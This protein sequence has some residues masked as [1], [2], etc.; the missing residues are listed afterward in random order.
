MKKSFRKAI[1]LAVFTA[2]ILTISVTTF[3]SG[4]NSV[5]AE[6]RN[7]YNSALKNPVAMNNRNAVVYPAVISTVFPD[8]KLADTV[9]AALGKQVSDS[10]TKADLETITTLTYVGTPQTAMYNLT[11]LDELT[12]L[13]QVEFTS[14]FISDLSLVDWSKLPNLTSLNLTNNAIKDLTTIDLTQ[15]S[16]LQ[17]LILDHNSITD[18]SGVNWAALTAITNISIAN[19]FTGWLEGDF[20][21]L[22][23]KENIIKNVNGELVPLTNITEGGTYDAATGIVT[24]LL[25]HP[26][27]MVKWGIV[28]CD[29]NTTFTV[30]GVAAQFSGLISYRMSIFPGPKM[31]F[32]DWDNRV[33]IE[34]ELFIGSD[35]VAPTDPVRPGYTFVG[36]TPKVLAKMPANSVTFKAVY[37]PIVVTPKPNVV[38]PTIHRTCQDDGY[39]EGYFWNGTACVLPSG[40]VVPNTGVK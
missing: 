38:E 30:N 8:A 39:A 35:I 34:E 15:L 4:Y 3:F 21:I 1:K 24:W 7:D 20:N 31:K 9:A 10:V 23:E 22:V 6:V 14:N 27:D 37:T 17:T 5:S 40:Y 25:T 19:Q 16:G 32:V 29:F 12:N 36:W 26:D 33:I 13:T 28:E 18:I 11:G 2:C